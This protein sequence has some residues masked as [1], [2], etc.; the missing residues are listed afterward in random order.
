LPELHPR[1]CQNTARLA[2]TVLHSALQIPHYGTRG[3]GRKLRR[4]MVFTLQP[5]INLGTWAV[6]ILADKLTAVTKDR[7]LSAQFEHMVA[8][9][10][11]GVEILT[12]S[13][14]PR[15]TDAVFG[16]QNLSQQPKPGDVVLG[17]QPGA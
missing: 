15:F 14:Y 2:V 5:M 3:Q 10:D 17:E 6:E 8:V 1:V 4:G 9:T 16:G 13:K 7:K 12:L 11:D